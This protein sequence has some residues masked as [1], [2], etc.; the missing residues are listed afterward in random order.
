M[1]FGVR[2]L[3]LPVTVLLVL[4]PVSTGFAACGDDP[5]DAPGMVAAQ[6]AADTQCDCCRARTH[7][8]YVRCV[9]QVARAAVHAGALR[10][11][12][13]RMVVHGAA[14]LPCPVGTASGQEP[15]CRPCNADADCQAG[16]FCE[17]PPGTCSKT[18]GTCVPRPS[19][20]FQLI[21]PVCG[22]DGTTYP[23]D[24][25]RRRARVCKRAN[26]PC[27]SGQCF[28]TVERQCT[29]QSC[30]AGRPCPLPNERCVPTCPPPPPT[31]TCFDVLDKQ[32]T[33]QPCSPGTPCPPDELC[34]AE[35]PPP[36]GMCFDTI[37]RQCTSQVCSPG[38]PCAL[39]NEFCTLRCPPPPTT[40]TTLPGQ[41]CRTDADCDDGNPCSADVCKNGVCE[42][43][44]LCVGAGGALT[45]CPGP[46]AFCGTTTTT[47]SPPP[48]CQTDAE[49]DVD[50]FCECPVGTCNT[51]GGTCVT[52]PQACP[53]VFAPVCGCNGTTYPND[54]ARQ[55]A[56]AC[57]LH[58]GACEPSCRTDGDC[59]DGNPCT[60]DL[61]RNGV[62]EHPCVCATAGGL[63]CCPGPAA[64]C[65]RPCGS[66]A[67]GTCGGFCP[68]GASCQSLPGAPACGCV[69]GL[70]GPCGGNLLAPAPVCAVRGSSAGKRTRTRRVS[71]SAPRPRPYRAF[72]S[73]SRDAP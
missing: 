50:Q 25:E 44:C 34:L 45:C 35:C 6:A 70:G 24:C 41:T 65:V 2:A 66:D 19:A 14:S 68:A 21:A 47:T 7:G 26:G 1:S 33:G 31:G 43:E 10:R 17:C 58:D 73:S 63:A 38:A 18:G 71:A 40:T 36:A 56:G 49:C 22:C 57:K 30:A 27:Q 48:S 29:G 8:Q 16:E 12:C 4:L 69:S 15:I 59:S 51:T 32:C 5:V 54:C 61:C 37:T 20:C 39:P 23:N 64:L 62:C 67:S 46:A 11:A 9:A 3:L 55:A 28:D 13:K 42:H 53:Q 60:A 72:P 52:K